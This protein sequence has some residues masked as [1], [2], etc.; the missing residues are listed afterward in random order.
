MLIVY[1]V[2]VKIVSLLIVVSLFGFLPYV[3]GQYIGANF[4][5]SVENINNDI[6]TRANV[7]W[8]RTFVNIPKEFLQFSA[9]N[10]VNG[11][12][13]VA[14]KNF[15]AINNFIALKN[16]T[17]G[18]KSVK[19]ILS[20]KLNFKHK[21]T[22]VPSDGTDAM[23]YWIE[24]IELF[25]KERN[26]GNSIDIL[27]VGNEP[28][29]ETETADVDKLSVFLNKLID[30]VDA[31]KTQN[32]W[33]Y[34]IFVGALNRTA[35]LK[36][37]VILQAVLNIAKNNSKVNGLDLHPHADA[38]A[39]VENDLKYIRNTQNF[40]KKITCTEISLVRLWDEHMLDAL[41]TWGT[42]NGYSPTMKLYEWLNLY[43]TAASEGKRFLKMFL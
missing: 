2:K 28:M 23:N 19:T 18:G 37:N 33:K 13:K 10:E 1:N 24:A 41:G 20:L 6:I 5:E 39:T 14:I 27:V 9:T 35:E 21:D 29:W 7:N 17:V 43:I 32:S 31:L 11:V 12:K 22:G 3:N 42:Q 38:I 40:T 25:L 36:S 4:N 8:A 26:L 34:D 30:K 16:H 15:D